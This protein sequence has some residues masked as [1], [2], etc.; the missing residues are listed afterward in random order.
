MDLMITCTVEKYFLRQD[1]PLNYKLSFNELR[2]FAKISSD[3]V[4]GLGSFC[5]CIC[6]QM[7]ENQPFR[8]AQNN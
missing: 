6:D 5:S 1:E 2:A 4:K 3:K 7:L 8:H